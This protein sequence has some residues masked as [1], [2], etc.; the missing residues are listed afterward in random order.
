DADVVERRGDD[1]AVELAPPPLREV[2]DRPGPDRRRDDGVRQLRVVPVGE[3]RPVVRPGQDGVSRGGGEE[4]GEEPGDR[5]PRLHKR[6]LSCSSVD[7]EI[8]RAR[9]RLPLSRD[10]YR[11]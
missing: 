10:L 1:E 5:K 4:R 2:R 9:V 7:F 11:I 3:P 6:T 8:A